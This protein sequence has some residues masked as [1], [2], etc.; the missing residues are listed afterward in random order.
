MPKSKQKKK[1]GR[2]KLHTDISVSQTKDPNTYH[3]EYYY[4]V[5]RKG[6]VGQKT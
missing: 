6:K 2:R 1:P 5:L 4:K 3:L